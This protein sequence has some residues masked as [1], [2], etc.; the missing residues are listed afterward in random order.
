MGRR[1]GHEHTLERRHP[2]RPRPYP[3]AYTPMPACPKAAA[4][5]SAAILYTPIP[6]HTYPYLPIPHTH[7]YPCLTHTYPIPTP[8]PKTPE[9][10][11]RWLIGFHPYS[12]PTPVVFHQSPGTRPDHVRYP[13]VPRRRLVEN[14]DRTSM[15]T[16]FAVPFPLVL[17][18][19][20]CA[21]RRRRIDANTRTAYYKN[22]IVI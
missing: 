9:P 21:R 4:R 13:D 11:G 6:T 12:H 7:A 3:F 19:S 22:K 5:P 10:S 17:F 15:S 2:I 20:F 16:Q 18:Q 14:L 1:T 8:H